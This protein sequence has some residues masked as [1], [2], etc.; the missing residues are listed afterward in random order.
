MKMHFLGLQQTPPLKDCHFQ[1]PRRMPL[2]VWE[3][4][5][6]LAKIFPKNS[7]E[8]HF[9]V[10]LLWWQGKVDQTWDFFQEKNY[11]KKMSQ[12]VT[13]LFTKKN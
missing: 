4:Q 5:K 8:P 9:Y 7:H 13:K 2:G 11:R 3:S 10:Q 6:F 1:A 12:K